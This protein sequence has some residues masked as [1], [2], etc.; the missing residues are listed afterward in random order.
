MRGR[1]G[2]EVPVTILFFPAERILVAGCLL[3]E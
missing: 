3:K 1:H 2:A